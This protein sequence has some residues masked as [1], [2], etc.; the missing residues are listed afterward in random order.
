MIEWPKGWEARVDGYGSAGKRVVAHLVSL[1]VPVHAF[2]IVDPA[3]EGEATGFDGMAPVNWYSEKRPTVLFVCTPVSTHY[4]IIEN[5]IENRN[6]RGLFVE[7]PLCDVKDVARMSEV[8][9]TM[10]TGTTVSAVGYN[11]RHH[12][13]V[14]WAKEWMENRTASRRTVRA[15]AVCAVDM[16]KWPGQSYG[17]ALL[18][19]SHEL[20]TLRY[21][22]GPGVVDGAWPYGGPRGCWTVAI[23]HAD[24]AMS[25]VE[26]RGNYDGYRRGLTLRNSI[27]EFAWQTDAFEKV[28]VAHV[29]SS[30]KTERRGYECVDGQWAITETYRET[31]RDFLA[32]VLDKKSSDICTLRQGLEVVN[33]CASAQRYAL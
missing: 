8:V 30:G 32:G 18:E 10:A 3:K 20:D 31:L 7:K 9:R 15:H 1:G 28:G 6:L 26:L 13:A 29:T 2:S 24:G 23:K 4:N 17:S 21:L 27:G 5:A 19:C 11:W 33:W 22:L 12:P 16:S 14:R 25:W